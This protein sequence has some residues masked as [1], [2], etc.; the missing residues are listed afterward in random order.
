MH[1]K[2]YIPNLLLITDHIRYPGEAFFAAGD[3]SMQGGVDAVLVREKQ[4]DSARLLS[5]CS[6]LR[7][8]TRRFEARLLVHTQADVAGAVGADGV[9]VSSDGIL[10]VR[11][12]RR[13]LNDAPMTLSASC[14]EATQLEAAAD[15]GADFALL[16]PV[17]PTASH[18]GAPDN[19]QGWGIID[20]TAAATWF[21]P[22]ISH[23]PLS[24]TGA[25]GPFTVN[26]VLTDRLGLDTATLYYRIDGG[27]W[28]MLPLLPTGQPDAFSADIP[29]VSQLAQIDYY[30][31][32]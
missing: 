17:F 23:T 29:A 27:L 21:G 3:A 22:V 6:R 7:D 19:D 32:A 31:T 15:A 16:S 9:H 20:A 18:P 28:Q 4:M 8:I 25:N 13:W 5:I 2:G 1:K 26:S 11:A 12:M 10:E 30:L 14:H 24:A